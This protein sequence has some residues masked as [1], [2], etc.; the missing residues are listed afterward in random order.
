MIYYSFIAEPI[1]DTSV[2]KHVVRKE[3]IIILL[4]IIH[5]NGRNV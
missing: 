4:L 5:P 3:K 2:M 1:N